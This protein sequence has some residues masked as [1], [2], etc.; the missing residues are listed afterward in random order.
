M[1]CIE[2]V[3]LLLTH[4]IC[5]YNFMVTKDDYNQLTVRIHCLL[6]SRL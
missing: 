1:S 2:L 6:F 5:R 3:V 4:S